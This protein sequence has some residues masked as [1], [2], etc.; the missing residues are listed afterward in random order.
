MG[1]VGDKD[2]H[3]VIDERGEGDFVFAEPIKNRKWMDAGHDQS[4][5]QFEGEQFGSFSF[6]ADQLVEIFL[7]DV[8]ASIFSACSESA[9]I[10]EIDSA[11]IDEHFC[12]AD[13]F[14]R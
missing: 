9:E 2:N 1:E 7:N 5:G 6:P 12:R 10:F 14:C 8:G 3:G 13:Q 11:T 4:T